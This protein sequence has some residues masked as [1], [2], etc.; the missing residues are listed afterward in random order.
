MNRVITVRAVVEA[1]YS[2]REVSCGAVAVSAVEARHKYCAF[3]APGE[4]GEASEG[5]G[6]AETPN[7]TL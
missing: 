3:V 7:G 5:E 1:L 4:G 6:S 2:K